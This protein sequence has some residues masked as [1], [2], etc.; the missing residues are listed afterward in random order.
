ML[1]KRERE[2]IMHA[3]G[4]TRRG[5]RGKAGRRWACRNY[6]AAGGADVVVWRGLVQ[7]GLARTLR[8]VN[9][10]L[11]SYPGFAVTLAGARA[12]GMAEYVPNSIIPREA[13]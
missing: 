3:L 12:A 11:C 13:E 6:F 8:A 1:D 9:P 7:R 10:E 4:L 2:A 5:G